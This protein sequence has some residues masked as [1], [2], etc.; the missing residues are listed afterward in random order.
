MNKTKVLMGYVLLFA[1]QLPAFHAA[2]FSFPGDGVR[3]FS[4]LAVWLL[5]CLG[6][7]YWIIRYVKRRW[8][9]LLLGIGVSLLGQYLSM[10]SFFYLLING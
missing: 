9:H 8:L 6:I 5:M 10:L 1:A 7:G 3:I 4:F 2:F